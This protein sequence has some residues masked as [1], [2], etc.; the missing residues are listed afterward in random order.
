MGWGAFTAM[1]W[2]Q[3]FFGELKSCKPHG[4]AKKK[5]MFLRNKKK[6]EYVRNKTIKK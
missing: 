5:K 6:L 1:T 3:S 2:I 4:V